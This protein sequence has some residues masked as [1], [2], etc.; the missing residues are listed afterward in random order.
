MAF[1]RPIPPYQ[2]ATLTL[3]LKGRSFAAYY[4]EKKGP[5]RQNLLEGLYTVVRQ[6][7]PLHHSEAMRRLSYAAGYQML[8]VPPYVE[9]WLLK[10]GVK[11]GRIE[12]RGEFLWPAGL[13]RPTVRDRSQLPPISRKFE[14]ICPEEIE[15]A[16]CLVVQDAWGIPLEDTPHHV[17]QLF[18]FRQIGDRSKTAVLSAIQ[19]LLAQGRLIQAGPELRL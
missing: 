17:G 13:L 9:V 15:E 12:Q 4:A 3:Q 14:H 18:G 1:L 2:P 6:E 19:R 10:E 11:S 8:T 5:Y 7:G 16:V